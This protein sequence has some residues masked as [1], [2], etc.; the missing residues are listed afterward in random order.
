[1]GIQEIKKILSDANIEELKG[2][3]P[4]YEKE[5]PLWLDLKDVK[6]KLTYPNLK[7]FWDNIRK[8]IEE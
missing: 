6:E 1:M 3:I 4:E 5:E 7:E 8:K 2:L